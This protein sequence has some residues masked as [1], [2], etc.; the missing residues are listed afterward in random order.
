MN[1]KPPSPP[2]VRKPIVRY[3]PKE[4]CVD[5]KGRFTGHRDVERGLAFFWGNRPGI[6]HE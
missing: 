2:R 3:K 4:Q 5:D 1:L 6:H